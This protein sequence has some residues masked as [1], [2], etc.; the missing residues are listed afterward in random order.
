MSHEAESNIGAVGW[1]VAGATA[2]AF[3]VL[4]EQ[5]MSRWYR[6]RVHDERTRNYALAGLAL[7]AYHLT[8]PDK[9]PYDR[10]DPITRLG[11]FVK[12]HIELS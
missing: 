10:I 7:S 8:R 11:A 12:N 2:L 5:T 4:A 6:D 1:L 9:Y 3:D